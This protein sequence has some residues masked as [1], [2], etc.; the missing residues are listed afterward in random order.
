MAHASKVLSDL[1]KRLGGFSAVG[2]QFGVT[3]WAVQ[4]WYRRGSVPAERVPMLCDLAALHGIEVE[5]WQIRPDVY[6]VA[7]FRPR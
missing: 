3:A 4:K 1:V 5:P 2:R 7:M 6:P